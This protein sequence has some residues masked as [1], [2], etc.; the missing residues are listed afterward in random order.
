MNDDRYA[1]EKRSAVKIIVENEKGEIL[2]I[3]EPL[4]NEWMPGRWG[5]PGGKPFV[6]EALSETY[7]RKLKEET[8]LEVEPV[9]FYRVEELLFEDRTVYMFHYVTRINSNDLPQLESEYVWAGKE[10][11]EKMEI[12]E[13]TEFFNKSLMLEYLGGN[14]SV[15]PVNAVN[16]WKFFQMSGNDEFNTWLN[17]K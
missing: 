15:Y 14:K 1:F 12:K 3:K 4:T 7:K 5:L 10:K 6:D 11:I 9:G 8:G 17:A 16:T 13:F 2:L